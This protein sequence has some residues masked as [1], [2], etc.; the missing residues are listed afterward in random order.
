MA[1][2]YIHITFH[3]KSNSFWPVYI[4]TVTYHSSKKIK[5]PKEVKKTSQGDANELKQDRRNLG[6][7][8]NCPPPYSGRN[9]GKTCSIKR[10]SSIPCP[11]PTRFTYL[12]A[13]LTETITRLSNRAVGTMG[14]NPS[15]QLLTEIESKP[16]QFKK[17]KNFYLP[18]IF[19]PSDG[20]DLK[21]FLD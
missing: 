10:L 6:Q 21:P 4:H 19:R 8:G 14:E 5:Y 13:A 12:P 9:R 1:L 18:K 7:G 16:V 11:S 2:G 15:P 20:P 17:R 3:W